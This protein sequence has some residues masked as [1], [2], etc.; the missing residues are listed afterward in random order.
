MKAILRLVTVAAV[1]VTG[2]ALAGNA[3]ATQKLSVTQSATSL[4]IRVTQTANDQQP[5]RIQ[6]YVPTGYQL[7]TSQA[8]GT[9]I[10]TTQGQVFARDQNIPLPLTGDVI[11][12]KPSDFTTN[13]CSPGT[14]QAVWLLQL[15]VAGQTIS[16]PVYVNSTSGQETALGS[17]RLT[18]CLAPSDT[19]QGSPGRS[20]FGAQ[21]LTAVFTVNNIFTPPVGA[22]RWTSFWT[23]YASGT[24]APNAAGTV[25][26][27][28]FVGPG[29]VTI[30][31]RVTN[32]KKHIV[33]LTGRVTYAGLGLGLTQVRLSVNNK[34]QASGR[35]NANGNYSFTLRKTSGKVRT[36]FFQARAISGERD[37]TATGCASPTQPGVACVSATASAF[38]VVSGK[39]KLKV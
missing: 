34:L 5:A 27:R 3:F 36:F 6:I 35:T 10:G 23:P 19:P 13:S 32:K 29:A 39:I 11:V 2:L 8:P 38:N 20:P 18:V 28:A 17:A 14:N 26:S 4:T 24:G 22:T 7:N 30:A 21:L 9:N 25:E 16:I 12:A 31:G 15:S 1:A 33:K 37:V